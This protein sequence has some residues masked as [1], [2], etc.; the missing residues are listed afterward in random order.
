[1]DLFI[2]TGMSG[3]MPMVSKRHARRTI[4]LLKD[5][6]RANLKLHYVLRCEQPVRM[7]DKLGTAEKR[8]GE[9]WVENER[10]FQERVDTDG[11]PRG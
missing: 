2:N 11:G 6:T 4:R 8:P 1:M 7:G 10:K 9:A 5:M 3:G